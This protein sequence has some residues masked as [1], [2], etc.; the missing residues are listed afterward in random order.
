LEFARRVF[1]GDADP[2]DPVSSQRLADSIRS[3]RTGGTAARNILLHLFFPDLY[4]DIASDDHK[5]RIATAFAEYA[6]DA[7][8]LDQ[9]LLNIRA[10]LTEKYQRPDLSFY[11]ADIWKIWHPNGTPPPPPIPNGPPP[12]RGASLT[13]LAKETHLSLSFLEE[14]TSLLNEKRQLV[15]EG[16]PGSGKTFVAGLFARQFAGLPL[17]SLPT[18]QVDIVQFHQSYGYEDFVQGIRPETDR[19]GKLR[20]V[21]RDGI[22]KNLC[23]LA[24]ENPDRKF[25]L[26]IDEINRGNIARI[27][28]ELLLLL[29]YREQR[30]RLPYAAETGDDA[31]LSIPTN[32]Y[33]IG[34]MNSTDRSLAQVDYAL[35]RRFYFVH[36]SPVENGRAPVLESWLKANQFASEDR[37]RL[38]RLFV[39]LNQRVE[40]LLG[41][42]FQI[43]HSYFMTKDIATDAGLDRVWRRAIRPLLEEYFH[44]HRDRESILAELEPERLLSHSAA[45][46]EL[47]LEGDE[48]AT[49]QEAL[50]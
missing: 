35:R 3:E 24:A 5:Q 4:E 46:E 26:L 21:V 15:F 9:Q 14:V 44:H 47:E 17:A 2:F 19:E 22:F 49:E 36:F 39:A 12:N 11:Q 20:Y 25:V 27:F 41:P 40:E 48:L 33:L 42:D 16:P 1:A 37:A 13:D 30:A 50:A 38:L 29:E 6:G 45:P 8:D 43:G 34:T 18:N 31:Y 23:N 32:L 10:A 7:T 28:G